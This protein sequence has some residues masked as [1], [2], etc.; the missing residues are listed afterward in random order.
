MRAGGLGLSSPEE[1]E[2][3]PT[4]AISPRR[5]GKNPPPGELFP[6]SLTDETTLGPVHYAIRRKLLRV[7]SMSVKNPLRVVHRAG[8]PE[9]FEEEWLGRV[10][11]DPSTRLFM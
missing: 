10:T 7:P 1:P 11:N 4:S 3:S 8:L 2:P 5:H 9:S 6:L